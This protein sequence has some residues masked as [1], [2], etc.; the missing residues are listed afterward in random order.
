M[1]RIPLQVHPGYEVLVT[2]CDQ[3][4]SQLIAGV[5]K[6]AL[7]ARGPQLFGPDFKKKKPCGCGDKDI[8]AI[9]AASARIKSH[10]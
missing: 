1:T 8:A 4:M 7:N 2:G 9:A 6:E 3:R 5:I 10:V